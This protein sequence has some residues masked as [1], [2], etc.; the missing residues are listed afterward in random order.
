MSDY[1]N[2]L[3]VDFPKNPVFTQTEVFFSDKIVFYKANSTIGKEAYLTTSYSFLVM[4][5]ES[6]S[7]KLE[8][9]TIIIERDKVV[10]IN[11]GQMHS[12]SETKSV[13]EYIPLFIEKN[14]LSELTYTMFG[15]NNDI[16]PN[17]NYCIN[18]ST[19][20][21]IRQF[22]EES[23][24]RQPGSDLILQCL[25]NQIAI[26]LLRCVYNPNS[27]E[28]PLHN[29]KV[30]KLAESYLRENY[31]NNLSLNELA[32][33]TN[34]SPY[35]FIRIFRTETGKTPFEYLQ[36]LKIAKSEKLLRDKK[37]SI[38]EVCYL[39]GFNNPSYF[40]NVFKKMKGISPSVFRDNI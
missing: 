16:I 36:D 23:T 32:K 5:Q 14:F 7:A 10:P 15:K 18:T 25:D 11:P 28:S 2:N 19:I 21:L 6:F 4:G 20:N 38:I 22:M 17:S 3:L 26:N 31:L 30:V 13:S 24:S 1:F 34:Y 40:S 27:E 37:L 39:S 29:K 35:H 8:G 33:Y 9:K 12:A